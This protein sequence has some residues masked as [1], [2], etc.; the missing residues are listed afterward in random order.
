MVFIIG[1]Q[2]LARAIATKKGEEKKIL[3]KY[4][5]AIPGLSFNPENRHKLRFLP[6][7]LSAGVLSQR[8]VIIWHDVINN[9]VRPTSNNGYRP[10][11]I[12]DLVAILSCFQLQ[13]EAIIYCKHREAPDLFESLR[14]IEVLSIDIRKKIFSHQ[15]RKVMKVTQRS[16]NDFLPIEFEFRIL[17]VIENNKKDL[18]KMIKQRGKPKASSRRRRTQKRR[19]EAEEALKKTLMDGNAAEQNLDS[20]DLLEEDVSDYELCPL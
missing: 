2:S 10:C 12:D 8:R 13:I 19:K 16:Q 1:A 20:K 5:F 18:P 9:S 15:S 17:K 14:R 4:I 7:L 3:K 11:S 6:T